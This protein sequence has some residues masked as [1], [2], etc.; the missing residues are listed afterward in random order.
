MTPPSTPATIR[1]RRLWRRVLWHRR[2]FAAVA[3]AVV[4]FASLQVLRPP[5]PPS[6]P[7]V[8]VSHDIAP[9]TR[10]GAGDVVLARYP[11]ALAPLHAL[12]SVAAAVGRTLASG[13]SQGTP[14]TTASLGGQAW[15]SLGGGDVAVPVRLQDG[16]LADILRPGE[17]VQLTAVDPKNPSGS[18]TLVE[19]AL[20]LAVPPASRDSPASAGRLV[21]F[22]VPAE[23]SNL[24]TSSAVSR[25]LSVAWGH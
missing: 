20:V 2:K 24:V 12:S 13:A 9:G 14:L 16:A 4:V 5:A 22:G 10:L 7:I 25:Y 8:T 19:D 23:R 3:A 6:T 15:S 21:I 18:E 1:Y 17:R 11:T